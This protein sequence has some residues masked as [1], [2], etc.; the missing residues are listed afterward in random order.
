MFIRRT[1]MGMGRVGILIRVSLFSLTVSNTNL[2][3]LKDKRW[4]IIQIVLFDYLVLT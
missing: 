3:T 1:F 2:I 4:S